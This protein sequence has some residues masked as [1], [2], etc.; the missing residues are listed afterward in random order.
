MTRLPF[1]LLGL[2]ALAPAAWAQT[3][4]RP[5]P[6]RHAPAPAQP[7]APP[8]AAEPAGEDRPW[9]VACT[10]ANNQRDCQIT[11]TLALR[12]SNERLARVI[13][14]RQPETRS[15]TMVFQLPHGAWL[16]AGVQWQVDD[17][18]AQRL[19]FQTSDAEGLY[20]G[21]PVTDDLLLGLRRGSTLRLAVVVAAQ[22]QVV[23]MPVPLARFAEAFTE[24]TTQEQR[25]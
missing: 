22:R 2:L 17:G 24:F 23:N 9:Q 11:A 14:R 8:A 5:A 3:A 10:T 12:Q 16:P 19:P 1:A 25:R 20:A 21:I 7:A 18:E 15:L 4:P 13:L 6:Q